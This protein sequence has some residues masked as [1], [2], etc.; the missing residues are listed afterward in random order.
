M[1]SA[2]SAAKASAR[3]WC[4]RWY[5]IAPL[6]F[7]KRVQRPPKVQWS[8]SE[9]GWWWGKQSGWQPPAKPKWE[10]VVRV[11]QL[12]EQ[13]YSVTMLQDVKYG[14]LEDH[15]YVL[16]IQLWWEASVMC[17]A[18]VGYMPTRG[19]CYNR[20]RASLLIICIPAL[21]WVC[22][23]RNGVYACACTTGVGRWGVQLMT[24]A[25]TNDVTGIY[26]HTQGV[27]NT[28]NQGGYVTKARQTEFA[29]YRHRPH[30]FSD[31]LRNI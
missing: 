22:C 19:P 17:S 2:T 1:V 23:T 10:G 15:Q 13:F 7:H 6:G 27:D 29:V 9:Q 30:R 8:G 20:Y 4:R 21:L 3:R 16:P 11:G 24:S 28:V 31:F 26:W 14:N 5:Q 18:M 25:A 12:L